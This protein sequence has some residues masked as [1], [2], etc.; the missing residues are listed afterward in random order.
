[1]TTFALRA[2]A[3]LTISL[4]LTL[5]SVSNAQRPRPSFRI[6]MIADGESSMLAERQ[7]MLKQEILELAKDDAR[8]TFVEPRVKPSWSLESS[9][10][11]LKAGL[12]DRSVDLIIVSGARTGVAV[13]RI[14]KLN[15]P[16]LI[17]YAAPELQGL[18]QAGNRSGRRNLASTWSM[19]ASAAMRPFD[20]G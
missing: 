1:M 3:I 15:K 13:S 4:G 5:G 17:P 2:L 20:R 19:R 12:A 8:V 14:P 18:P 11:A 9:T 7:E 16:V 6:M 10:A